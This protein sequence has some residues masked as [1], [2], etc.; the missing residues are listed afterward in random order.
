V[1][2]MTEA[3]ASRASAG[4][5]VGAPDDPALSVSVI[6][7]VHNGGDSLAACLSSLAGL[8]PAAREIIVIDDGSTDDSARVAGQFGARV[9]R[10]AKSGP[11]HARNLG[12]K[13]AA[14]DI[15]YFVDADV[16]VGPDAIG[17]IAGAFRSQP[18]LAALFGSYDDEPAATDFL[19]QYKNLQQHYVHQTAHED[20]FTF[21][22]GCGAILRDIFLGLGGFD[23]RYRQPTIEDI[24]LG[25]RLKRAGHGI[26]LVKTLQVKHLKRWSLPSLLR[27]DFS[28]RAVPWARLI[29]RYGRF[30]NDLNIGWPSRLSVLAVHVLLGALLA[31]WWWPV[32][33]AVAGAAAVSLLLLNR[34]IYC[35]LWRK[36]G[37]FF[38]LQA[39][40]WH[41]LYYL[42]SGLGFAFALA[43]HLLSLL[44]WRRD[45]ETGLRQGRPTGEEEVSAP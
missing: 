19:S 10:T 15:L 39:I 6:I 9:L 33:W 5:A 26:R 35:F 22:T 21:W 11:A 16:A 45:A 7:P 8:R 24:E 14:G 23:E 30:T 3:A 28:R 43:G 40:P 38:A 27:S 25:Y 13:M 36:R 17:Q 32:L 4:Q 2:P 12:A 41:W 34:G 37:W 44:R 18:R 1:S 31:A 42:Y 29:L 20:A